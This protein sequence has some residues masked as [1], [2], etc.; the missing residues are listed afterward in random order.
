MVRVFDVQDVD[1]VADG[2]AAAYTLIG[3]RPLTA[4][5]AVIPFEWEGEHYLLAADFGG[6]VLL[7][8]I[9]DLLDLPPS[10][11]D[12]VIFPDSATTPYSDWMLEEWRTPP[13]VTDDLPNNVWDIAL[14]LVDT[15]GDQVKDRAQVYVDVGRVGIVILDFDPTL[16]VGAR[17]PRSDQFIEL[18]HASAGLWVRDDPVLGHHLLVSDSQSGLRVYGYQ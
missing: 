3:P 15:D 12:S 1:K 2:S 11:P 6:S 13:C 17:M 7:W 18:P 5:S 16:P 8:R 14:D 10:V 9:T 4:A